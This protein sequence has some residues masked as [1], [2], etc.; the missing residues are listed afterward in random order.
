MNDKYKAAVDELYRIYDLALDYFN[1]DEEIR[2]AKTIITIQSRGNK[3]FL[4]WFC[5]DSWDDNGEIL[6]EINLSAER[7]DLPAEE[8]VNVLLHELAHKIN[9]ANKI[10]DCNKVQYHKKAF[11]VQAEKL[12]LVVSTVPGKGFAAT[13]LGPQGLEF[14]KHCNINRDIF[15]IKR[16]EHLKD[17]KESEV[18]AIALPKKIWE[19][20]IQK[21]IDEKDLKNAKEVV[22]LALEKYLN[23][24]K[25]ELAALAA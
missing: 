4:G 17:K 21:E 7:L 1:V 19:E 14:F 6:S 24:D 16:I 18:I 20:I 13:G 2:K 5:G 22:E 25:K 3:K 15:K 9:H 12:G 10:D 23:V 11:K 8:I